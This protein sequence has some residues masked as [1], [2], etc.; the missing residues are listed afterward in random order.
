MQSRRPIGVDL[1][2]AALGARVFRPHAL[3][4][5]SPPLGS[6]VLPAV[7]RQV[8]GI[9]VLV[10]ELPQQRH[11]QLSET[12]QASHTSS[13]RSIDCT[14]GD[15]TTRPSRPPDRIPIQSRIESM[16]MVVTST[17]KIPQI[18]ASRRALKIN[19]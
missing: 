10:G 4:G 17:R 9:S 12:P 5:E 15:S 7:T 16:R 19:V 13:G 3:F 18:A 14:K 2:S 1:R 11:H 8:P 6:G